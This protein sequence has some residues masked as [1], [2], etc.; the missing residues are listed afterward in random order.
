[1]YVICL[2]PYK[3]RSTQI[4]ERKEEMLIA[5]IVVVFAT[6]QII[7]AGNYTSFHDLFYIFFALRKPHG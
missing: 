6:G 1:M 4:H 2:N 7:I 3:Y 5:T